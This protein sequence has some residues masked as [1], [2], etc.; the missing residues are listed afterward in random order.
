MTIPIS[1]AYICGNDH[2]TSESRQCD[3][4]SRNLVNLGKILDRES[5]DKLFETLLLNP[6]VWGEN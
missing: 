5:A 6:G 2:V 3:C 4:G 1:S